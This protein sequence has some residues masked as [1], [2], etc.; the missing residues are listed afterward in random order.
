MISRKRLLCSVV[1]AGVAI[2]ALHAIVTSFAPLSPAAEPI[3]SADPF[4]G[5]PRSEVQQLADQRLFDQQQRDERQ[6]TIRQAN[7]FHVR[8]GEMVIN[9]LPWDV[10][11]R[12]GGPLRIVEDRRA[13]RRQ[14]GRSGNTLSWLVL[15]RG[16]AM[17]HFWI[18]TQPTTETVTDTMIEGQKIFV[19][20]S[21]VNTNRGLDAPLERLGGLSVRQTLAK[22]NK[23]WPVT[24]EDLKEQ[25]KNKER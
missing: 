19:N 6:I 12:Y 18:S 20:V 14:A 5:P 8:F 16:I 22:L 3:V 23:P 4:S 11:Y 2:V 10:T 9:E 24:L 1:P 17:F 7:A 13:A 21:H 15:A 25:A